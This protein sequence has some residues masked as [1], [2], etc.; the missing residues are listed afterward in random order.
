[1]RKFAIDSTKLKITYTHKRKEVILPVSRT[2]SL[3]G[4]TKVLTGYK[5]QKD[6][7]GFKSHFTANEFE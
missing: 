5:R 6:Y 2:P 1:M 4:S 7:R 3:E